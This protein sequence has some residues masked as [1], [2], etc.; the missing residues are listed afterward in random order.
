MA[1]RGRLHEI[2]ANAADKAHALGEQYR[3]K[4]T[5]AAQLREQ[6]AARLDDWSDVRRERQR[7]S[8]DDRW[9]WKPETRGNILQG[10]CEPAVI[11]AALRDEDAIRHVPKPRRF[12][13]QQKRL[14]WEQSVKNGERLDPDVV[15]PATTTGFEQVD[16]SRPRRVE[17]VAP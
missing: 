3:A 14:D 7:L 9:S 6:Y 5:E 17:R 12:S 16:K 10:A 15:E 2:E 8:G 11:L 1:V 4:L 13:G